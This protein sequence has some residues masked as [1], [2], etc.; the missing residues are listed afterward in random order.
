MKILT[1][2]LLLEKVQA[3]LDLSTERKAGNR[4]TDIQVILLTEETF[5]AEKE[6]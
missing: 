6:K 4:W 5:T 1:P 3:T 2:M